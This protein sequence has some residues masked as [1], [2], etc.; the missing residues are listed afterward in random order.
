M[1]IKPFSTEI[2]DKVSNFHKNYTN[3]AIR[4][5]KDLLIASTYIQFLDYPGLS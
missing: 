4:I 2:S 3:T 1:E 5:T